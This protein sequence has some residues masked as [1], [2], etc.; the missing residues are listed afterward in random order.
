[1]VVM[2]DLTLAE[3]LGHLMAVKKVVM[4]AVMLGKMMVERLD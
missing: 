2:T 4:M 1:M 3:R